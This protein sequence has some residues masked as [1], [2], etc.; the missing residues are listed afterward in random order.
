M[1]GSNTKPR[2]IFNANPTV[3]TG[4]ATD[5]E[6]ILCGEDEELKQLPIVSIAVVGRA[7]KGKSLLAN[8]FKRWVIKQQLNA[9]V[10]NARIGEKPN[11]KHTG[12]N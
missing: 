1:G 8:G 3:K 11:W 5:L 2:E 9:A 12:L 4:N 6:R 10:S 7:R